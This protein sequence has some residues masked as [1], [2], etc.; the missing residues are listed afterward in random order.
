MTDR[1]LDRLMS[2]VLVIGVIISALL[3][4][5]GFG[6]SFVV[7]W[8]GSLTGAT[9]SQVDPT[10]FSSLIE[11]LA[12]LQPL[13]VVQAGLVVLIATPV[14]RVAVTAVGFWRERDTLYTAVTL[15]VLGLLVVSL[16]FFR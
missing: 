9:F 10:D 15:A 5:L 8:T 11:R 4:A 6:A 2:V 3:I 14:I 16:V 13:A 7:G 1:D 12:G